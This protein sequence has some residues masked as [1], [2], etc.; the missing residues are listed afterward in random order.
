MNVIIQNYKI[1]RFKG[2]KFPTF[3]DSSKI[4]APVQ[5]TGDYR[6]K[7]IGTSILCYINR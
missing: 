1:S 2:K 5:Q 3:F 7:Q 4:V 6:G